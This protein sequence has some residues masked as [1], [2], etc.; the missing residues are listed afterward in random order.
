M[1]ISHHSGYIQG[2]RAAPLERDKRAPRKFLR[3][4][5]MLYYYLTAVRARLIVFPSSWAV[6]IVVICV[7]LVYNKYTNSEH[8]STIDILKCLSVMR[9][10]T[11]GVGNTVDTS[12]M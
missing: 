2:T 5:Y 4:I 1:I 7:S 12:R 3:G 11:S 9:Q 10:A 6:N 8:I